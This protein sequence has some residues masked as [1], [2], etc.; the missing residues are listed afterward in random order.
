MKD[1]L[2][3][4][5]INFLLSIMIPLVAFAVG[6]GVMTARVDHVEKMTTGLQAEFS[7]QQAVNEDIKVRLAEIQKDILYIRQ[8]LEAHVK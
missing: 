3:K 1:Y 4:P 5:E 2:S 6:W 8:A 7:I